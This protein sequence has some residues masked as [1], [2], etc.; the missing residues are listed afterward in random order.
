MQFTLDELSRLR[1]H[2][3]RTDNENGGRRGHY[4]TV[5][6]P[7]KNLQF[8]SRHRRVVKRLPGG[9]TENFSH[10]KSSQATGKASMKAW[11]LRIHADLLSTDSGTWNKFRIRIFMYFSMGELPGPPGGL[12]GLTLRVD[13]SRSSSAFCLAFS[14]CWISFMCWAC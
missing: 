2:F 12:L 4:I 9:Q 11:S 1:G 3:D 14:L 5:G 6:F 10:L 7:A 13:H 8:T